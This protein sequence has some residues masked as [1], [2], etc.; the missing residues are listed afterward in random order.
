VKSGNSSPHENQ[1]CL[2][3]VWQ[4]FAS[5]CLPSDSFPHLAEL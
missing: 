3:D 2:L 4:F 5:E 1:I